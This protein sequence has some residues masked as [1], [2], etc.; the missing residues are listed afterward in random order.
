[1]SNFNENRQFM[2][3]NFYTDR[4]VVPKSNGTIIDC[5]THLTGNSI[6]IVSLPKVGS[7]IIKENNILKCIIDRKSRRSY[8]DEDMTLD[9]LGYLL[10]IT[11]GVTMNSKDQQRRV[12]PA[13]GGIYP[14]ETY[15]FINRVTDLKKGFYRYIPSKHELAYMHRLDDINMN[16]D[17]IALGQPFIMNSSFILFWSCQPGKLEWRYGSDS[18]RM[19][20]IDA[21]HACQNL[22]I[23]CESIRCGACAIAAYYQKKVDEMLT[24]DENE[25]VIYMAAVGKISDE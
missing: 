23:G 19:M 20:L 15:I 21:G 5:E 7:S 18:H 22:Y 17:D 24:L 14:F 8:T 11:Q 10:W 12:V 3:S 6:N 25:F 1:M 4:Y 2:K 9:E 13:A 16:L